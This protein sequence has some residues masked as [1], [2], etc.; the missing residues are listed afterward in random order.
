MGRKLHIEIS[1]IP[2]S[3][4]PGWVNT[5]EEVVINDNHLAGDSDVG[6]DPESIY[7][8]NARWSK[9]KTQKREKS[10]NKKHVVQESAYHSHTKHSQ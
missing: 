3:A 5:Y 1:R 6:Y 2:G 4:R 7:K 8:T 9:V 10:V